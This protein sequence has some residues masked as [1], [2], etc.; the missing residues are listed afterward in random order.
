MAVGLATTNTA[1][2]WLNVLRGTTFTGVA[3]PFGQLHTA[4]PGAAG[5]T[6][7][8]TGIAT[9]SAIAWAAASG[10]SMALS[11]SPSWSATGADTITHVTVWSASTAGTFYLSAA[12]TASKTVAS[13]DT[14][15]LTTLTVS[16]SPLAA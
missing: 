6:G 12:L 11:S 3:T 13:G 15:T 4:D 14:F 10:G 2:A 9:R 7:V 16:L 1:N 8:S 5:T